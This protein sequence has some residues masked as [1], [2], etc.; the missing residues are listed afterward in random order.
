MFLESGVCTCVFNAF[1]TSGLEPYSL[2]T[3]GRSEAEVGKELGANSGFP[4]A[5]TRF[6][7]NTVAVMSVLLAISEAVGWKH[8]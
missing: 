1:A 3:G 5:A 4:N 8:F 6:K 2:C 7:Q